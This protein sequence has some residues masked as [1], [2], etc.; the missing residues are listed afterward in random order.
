MN[1]NVIQVVTEFSLPKSGFICV[2]F[3]LLP[4][5]KEGNVFTGV[6]LSTIGPMATRSLLILVMAR[7]VRVLLECILV[8]NGFWRQIKG[9]KRP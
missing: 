5:M 1:N 2:L 7:S 6:C 8:S 3:T 4:T 9:G